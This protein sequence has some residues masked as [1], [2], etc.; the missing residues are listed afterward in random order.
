MRRLKFIGVDYWSRPVY[1]DEKGKLRKDI[2]LGRGT[3]RL[4][5]AV[6]N[7]FEGEPDMPIRGEFEIVKKMEKGGNN[8]PKSFGKTV[9]NY[10]N[11]L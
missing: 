5:S 3:P 1:K 8:Y 9:N 7:D 2:E 6:N 11:L 10:F 4:R